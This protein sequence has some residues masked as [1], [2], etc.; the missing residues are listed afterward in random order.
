MRPVKYLFINLVIS[1]FTW[2]VLP[3]DK[4][5]ASISVVSQKTVLYKLGVPSAER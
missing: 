3:Q 1:C 5:S 2:V 4:S